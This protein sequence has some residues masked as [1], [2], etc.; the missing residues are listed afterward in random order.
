MEDEIWLIKTEMF[1]DDE[2]ENEETPGNRDECQLAIKNVETTTI[3]S[4]IRLASTI[5][6]CLF[7]L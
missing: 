1:E 3:I 5:Y 2:S 4:S 7:P 6:A